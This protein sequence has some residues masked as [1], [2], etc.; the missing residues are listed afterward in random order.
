MNVSSRRWKTGKWLQELDPHW[1]LKE[2]SPSVAA[3]VSI[4]ET[5]RRINLPVRGYL[6]SVLPGLANFL[7]NRVA[8]LTPTA[9]AA[10]S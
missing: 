5:C 1:Q 2:A 10:R 4:I 9:W 3:I 6:A 7:V 8:E